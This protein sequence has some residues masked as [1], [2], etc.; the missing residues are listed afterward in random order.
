MPV[1]RPGPIV[2][3]ASVLAANGTTIDR[4]ARQELAARRRGR[5]IVLRDASVE[6]ARLISFAGLESVLRIEPRGKAEQR[7]EPLGV[8]EEGQLADPTG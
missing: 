7:E 8:E 4:L 6:L 1:S 5:Q 2:V 3:D